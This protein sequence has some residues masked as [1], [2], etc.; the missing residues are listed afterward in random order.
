MPS[1]SE[2]ITPPDCSGPFGPL[3]PFQCLQTLGGTNFFDEPA[4]YNEMLRQNFHNGF[5]NIPST[6]NQRVSTIHLLFF[7]L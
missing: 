1:V 7:S 4:F 5:G 3:P 2:N 6:S